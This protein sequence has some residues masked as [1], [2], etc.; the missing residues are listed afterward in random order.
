V[1]EL[2]GWNR[3]SPIIQILTL[4]LALK[5]A[6]IL[7]LGKSRIYIQIVLILL[8]GS[9]IDS[10]RQMHLVHP[11]EQRLIIMKKFISDYSPKILRNCA[12]LQLP[13]VSYPLNGDTFRMEDYDHFLVS[14][15]DRKHNFSY[16]NA[17]LNMNKT[18]KNTPLIT[19]VNGFCAIY[20]DNFGESDLKLEKYLTQKYGEPISSLDNRY[21]LFTFNSTIG[22]SK[23]RQEI[24]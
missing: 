16:G 6:Q 20:L 8:T 13:N 5:L 7:M 14:V 1:P 21:K 10:V 15:L 22:V 17:R 24:K 4:V 2:R 11:Q 12:L 9:Q 23:K 3:L 18:F 19:D